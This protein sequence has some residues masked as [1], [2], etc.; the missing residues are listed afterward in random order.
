MTL[1]EKIINVVIV[2]SVFFVAFIW[3]SIAM[4]TKEKEVSPGVNGS[5]YTE[6]G[7]EMQKVL[8]QIQEY[9]KK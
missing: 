7:P 9:D 6:D 3:T 2:I 5:Y 1:N 4:H 8:K